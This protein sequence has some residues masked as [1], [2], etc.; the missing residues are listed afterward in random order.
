M[1]RALPLPLAA[2]L[3]LV[4]AIAH[5]ACEYPAAV[6]IPDGATA[7]EQEMLDAQSGVKKYMEE[8]QAYLNCMDEEAAALGDTESEEQKALHAK[9]HN[10]AVT[11]MEEL[12]AAFNE[13][14]RLYKTA[15]R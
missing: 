8:M 14:V 10:A 4:G 15:E 7:S 5:A 3:S 12:A 2:A 9:R 1:S 13:Q 6:T 11:A